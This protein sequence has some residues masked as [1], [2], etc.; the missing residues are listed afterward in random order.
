MALT[1]ATLKRYVAMGAQV[2]VDKAFTKIP[3]LDVS[4]LEGVSVHQG[5][6]FP[7]CEII[8]TLTRPSDE[9]LDASPKGAKWL[10]LINPFVEG[11]DTAGERYKARGLG[12]V[13]MEFL[14]RSSLAQK[15]DML[16]SQANLAGYAAIL[17][18]AE[19]SGRILPMM[20]TPSGTL[21]PSRVFVIGVGVAGLQAIATAKRL[22]ARIEAFDTRPVVE[23]QVRSL[24]AKFVKIDLGETGQNAQGYAQELTPEQLQ[25][26]KDAQAKVIALSDVVVT[27]AKLFGRKPPLLV[28][29]DVIA[30]MKA[31]SVIIDM[32]SMPDGSGNVEGSKFDEV[33]TTQ[34]GVMIYGG[35]ALE[36]LLPT[37]AS[38]M[39]AANIANFIE[40]FWDNDAKE[41]KLN[42]EEEMLTK[43]I[44]A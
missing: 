27:T 42:P 40:H 26:Q 25:K 5:E 19:L 1:A 17:K 10:G 9:Q 39:A 13:S 35:G 18:A 36:R 23:E 30:K 31:G 14:P 15:M 21:Q 2:I 41:L 29:A 20:M 28:P 24:G 33:V 22:G 43:M 37:D 12:A 16:S 11:L 3:S 6:G 34:N 38:E 8:V 7:E 4:A 44:F 32:A